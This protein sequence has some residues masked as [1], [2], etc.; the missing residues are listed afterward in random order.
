MNLIDQ[1]VNRIKN[2]HLFIKENTAT[3]FTNINK[4]IDSTKITLLPYHFLNT[5]DKKYILNR[6]IIEV[7]IYHVLLFIITIYLLH[8]VVKPIFNNNKLKDVTDIFLISLVPSI[9]SYMNGNTLWN[10]YI[11]ANIISSITGYL[12]ITYMG[13]YLRYIFLQMTIIIISFVFMILFNSIDV[14]AITYGLSAHNLVNKIG[15]DYIYKWLLYVIASFIILQVV[16]YT[17]DTIIAYY[18]FQYKAHKDQLLNL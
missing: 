13:K 1:I 18:N 7:I 17:N 12:V 11:I 15:T 14:T 2:V 6:F 3:E 16:L 4:C 10:G 9:Y 8:L 5:L